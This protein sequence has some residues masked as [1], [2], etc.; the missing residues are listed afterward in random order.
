MDH[1]SFSRV[2]TASARSQPMNQ[3]LTSAARMS[4]NSE[5]S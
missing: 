2:M 5:L 1:R 4:S 3:V